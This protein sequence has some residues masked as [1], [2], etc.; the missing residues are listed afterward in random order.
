MNNIID[1]PFLRASSF[2]VSHDKDRTYH[3]TSEHVCEEIKSFKKPERFNK[4]KNSIMSAAEI[5]DLFAVKYID[6]ELIKW[7]FI[8]SKSRINININ[9]GHIIIDGTGYK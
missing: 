3:I 2:I 6:N 5:S 8:P 4:V 7:T 1:G 9:M